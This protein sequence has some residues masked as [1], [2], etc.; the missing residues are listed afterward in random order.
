MKVFTLVNQTKFSKQYQVKDGSDNPEV[1][2]KTYGNNH[3][4]VSVKLYDEEGAMIRNYCQKGKAFS[5]FSC[6]LTGKRGKI[7]NVIKKEQWSFN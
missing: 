7:D 4:L 2:I 6:E 3:Q 5:Q 1:L